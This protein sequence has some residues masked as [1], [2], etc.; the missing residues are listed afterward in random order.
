MVGHQGRL[1]DAFRVRPVILLALH[2]GRRDQPNLVAMPLLCYPAP[3]RSTVRGVRDT[4]LFYKVTPSYPTAQTW[5]LLF[6]RSTAS[7]L[8]FIITAASYV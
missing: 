7:M 1:R 6:A 8:T 3:A 4:L 2:V 5:K